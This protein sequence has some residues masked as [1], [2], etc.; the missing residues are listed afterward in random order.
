MCDANGWV[1]KKCEEKFDVPECVASGQVFRFEGKGNCGEQGGDKGD[2]FVKVNVK[3]HPKFAREGKNIF[4]NEDIDL[5][6]A[7]LGGEI[8]IDV[9]GNS[10]NNNNK[11]VALSV[12]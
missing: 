10:N 4:S 6:T 9:L 1:V 7:V 3:S 8:E 12:A 11:K 2:L 5:V